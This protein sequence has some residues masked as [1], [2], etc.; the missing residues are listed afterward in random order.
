MKKLIFILTGLFAFI[1]INAQSLEE[2][3]KKQAKACGEEKFDNIKTL[4]ITGK[5]SQMGMDISMVSYYKAPNKSK[6]VMT[7]NGA[8][9]VQVFDGEKAY[10]INPMTGSNN[11]QEMSSDQ[12]NALKNNS[13]FKSPVSRYFKEGK[14]TLTGNDNV[15]SKPAFKLKAVDGAVSYDFYIDKGSFL[16]VKITTNTSGMSFDQDIEYGEISGLML[17]KVSTTKTSGMEIKMT[18]DKADINIPI[19]DSVFKVK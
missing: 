5:V 8:E 13:S 1:I 17:P 2:I 10:M 15:N 19:D 18:L 6:V 14:L 12:A 11:P 9:I 16:P 7:V 3:V 4:M